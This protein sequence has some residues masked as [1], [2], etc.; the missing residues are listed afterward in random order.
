MQQNDKKLDWEDEKKNVWLFALVFVRSWYK[1]LAHK[2]A[3]LH[4]WS[5]DFSTFSLFRLFRS[6]GSHFFSLLQRYLF[7]VTSINARSWFCFSL[8]VCTL[9]FFDHLF[10]HSCIYLFISSFSKA[11]HF[12]TL[13]CIHQSKHLLCLCDFELHYQYKYK[14]TVTHS[15]VRTIL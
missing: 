2:T 6:P 3:L 7:V 1:S 8:S 5:W 15:H 10:A 11:I 14:Y 9:L 4:L 13:T 12:I